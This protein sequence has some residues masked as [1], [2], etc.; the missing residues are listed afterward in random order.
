MVTYCWD[1][2][3]SLKTGAS[4][5]ILSEAYAQVMIALHPYLAPA[6]KKQKNRVK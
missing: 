2:K 4:F 3:N 6:I 1:E 5:K